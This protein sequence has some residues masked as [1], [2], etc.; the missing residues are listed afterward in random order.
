[1]CVH[2]CVVYISGVRRVKAICGE[3]VGWL[4]GVVFVASGSLGVSACRGPSFCD[5]M[6]D[7]WT[8]VTVSVLPQINAVISSLRK[9]LVKYSFRSTAPPQ[10]HWQYLQAYPHCLVRQALKTVSAELKSVYFNK[11]VV[12]SAQFCILTSVFNWVIY[13]S[14]I[15]EWVSSQVWNMQVQQLLCILQIVFFC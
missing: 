6:G 3:L 15:C 8:T 14:A 11:Q 4:S 9:V 2:A 5:T 7:R 1:M 10:T 13:I 12:V